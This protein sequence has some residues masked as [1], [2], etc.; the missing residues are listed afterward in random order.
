MI[1]SYFIVPYTSISVSSQAS[2]SS[3]H[4]KP[5]GGSRD[6]L[7]FHLCPAWSFF[8]ILWR[9]TSDGHRPSLVWGALDSVFFHFWLFFSEQGPHTVTGHVDSEGRVLMN[10]YIDEYMSVNF[11]YECCKKNGKC[12][13]TY[14]LLP[15]CILK[16][17]LFPSAQEEGGF[18]VNY[19]PDSLQPCTSYEFQVRCA[20]GVGLSSDWSAIH[21][22]QGIETSES[23][24]LISL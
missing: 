22:V 10:C 9:S 4:V 3:C 12:C 24:F 6:F 13:W 17:V 2:P 18:Y 16:L 19:T 1:I 15:E 5:P 21:R 11:K 7:E 8:R 14:L 20:C 23:T